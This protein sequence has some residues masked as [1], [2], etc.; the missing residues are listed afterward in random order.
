FVNNVSLGIY[1]EIVQS[2]AY[3][4]AKLETMEKMLPELLGPRTT[5]FDLR[6]QGPG[7]DEHRSAQL[8][9]VSNKIPT[10]S[11]ASPGWGP[12]RAFGPTHPSST[13]SGGLVTSRTRSRLDNLGTPQSLADRRPAPLTG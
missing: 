8:V 1:A 4:D 6:F 13:G 3:R 12:G 9:L 5:R 7:G 10:D 2:D 11:T